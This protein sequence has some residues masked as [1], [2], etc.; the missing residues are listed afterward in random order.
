[1]PYSYA[2][3]V[4]TGRNSL[5]LDRVLNPAVR[6]GRPFDDSLMRP[7]QPLLVDGPLACGKTTLLRSLAERAEEAGYLAVTATCSPTE[8]DLPFG[9]VSQLARGVWKTPDGPAE[10]PGLPAILSGASD[11]ADQAETARLCHRLC[12][13]LIDHAEHTPLLLAVDD[14]RHSDPASAHFLLQLLRR[15]DAARI[16][17]VF[18]DDLSLPAPSLPLRYELLR[19]Q[20]LRRIGLGPLTR[21]QVADVVAAELGQTA[22][23]R[24]GDVYAATG[25]NR[26][27]LHTLLADYREHGEARQTGYG[28]SFLSCLHRNEPIFLD[29]VRALAVVGSAL[30]AADLAW[31]TGHEPEPVG[32]VLTALTGAGLMDEGA[33]RHEAARLS[34]LNDMPGPARRNLH[35]RAARLLHDQ[36]RPA[37]TIARHLVRAGQIPDSW[38]AEVLL[39]VAEQVAVGEDA[40]IAVDL[41]EQSFDQCRHE[42]RRAALQAKLAEAEWKINPSTATRHHAPLYSAARSGRLGLSD[43][44]TLLMQLLWKGSLTEVEGLLAQLRHDPA[45][46]DRVHAIE[47]A[48]TCTYP[49][50]AERGSA[51]AQHGGAAATRAA[52][53]PRAGTVLADV[54]TGGQTHDTVR[55]AE[56]VLRELQLGHD[57]ACQ[58]QAGLFALLALVYGGRIDLASAWCE[59]ALGET[60]GGPHVP[61]WQAVLAAARSEIALRRGDLAEAAELS[62]AALTH[63]SPGAWGVAIGLPLGSLILANTRMGRYEEAGLH[64]AQT[65]PNAMFKS[66]YGLHYLYARGHYFLAVNRHQAALADFLLCGELLTEWGLS[67]GCDP[68][69]W[70]IGAA[71]AWLAQGNHDQARILVY[72][73]L[74]RPHPDGARARGQSLRLL[75][76]TSSAKRRPQLLGE[77]VGLFNEQEDKYELARTLWDLSQAH[78]ALGEKKQARRTMRR[79]WH[80]AKMCEAASLYEEWLPAEDQAQATALMP[81]QDTGIDRLTHSERRVASLAAM[82]Y[83]NR[84]I[85]GKL[86]VTAST[87]EQ[88]LT[89]VFRK[90]DIKHREQLPPELY[91]DRAESA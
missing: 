22:G 35:Q 53:W 4:N 40:S 60:G 19:S 34:V 73:Q 43:S 50:L 17:A 48:L 47:A 81:K 72:Q 18:S 7:G 77:A 61:V 56:E 65:V 69:P 1:M 88:H 91:A 6:L 89:R 71:E 54:L 62:R 51:P 32:Q 37:A 63:V 11:P 27:L 45:A 55:R 15:L 44:V 64:V 30:P 52:V 24:A 21:D 3:P 14:V 9:V 42:E 38:S 13:A 75:A 31:M 90:L 41:L 68:V 79:A 86:F 25:G 57:P 2:L 58:E 74:G 36:G 84:E 29:V 76:A 33:F 16:V 23:H 83:T 78:H 39:E 12:T 46:A 49:W 80:V 10:V 26:L 8:R 66:S 70:R 28:Q 59:G 82:G 20:S 87:V 5:L 85:A 67:S